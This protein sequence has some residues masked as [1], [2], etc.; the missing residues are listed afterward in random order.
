MH[1]LA[2]MATTPHGSA[3]N[4]GLIKHTHT[5]THAQYTR[6]IELPAAAGQGSVQCIRLP[7]WTPHFLFDTR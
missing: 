7:K 2:D 1:P 6:A 3:H 4:D 5:L